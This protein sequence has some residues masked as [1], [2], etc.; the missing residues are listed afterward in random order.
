LP[1][2]GELTMPNKPTRDKHKYG[3]KTKPRHV[4]D[5]LQR[6]LPQQVTQSGSSV[7]RPS[8]LPAPGAAASVAT[9]WRALLQQSLEPELAPHIS[10]VLAKPRELVVFTESAAWCTRLKLAVGRMTEVAQARDAS[11]GKVQ[12]RIMPRG[13]AR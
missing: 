6:L 3:A 13:A 2:I 4:A 9:Q 7:P 12:V 8:A 10:N 5:V 1:K 11:I